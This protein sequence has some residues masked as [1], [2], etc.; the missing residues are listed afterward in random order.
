MVL[1]VPLAVAR[2][3]PLRGQR[4]LFTSPGE[5]GGGR[6]GDSLVREGADML[7]RQPYKISIRPPPSQTP[8][9]RRSTSPKLRLVEVDQF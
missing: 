6:T 1:T 4:F 2:P 5:A 9:R 7:V 3:L 8:E